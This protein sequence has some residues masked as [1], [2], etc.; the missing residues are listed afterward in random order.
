MKLHLAKQAGQRAAS[1]QVS[2]LDVSELPADLASFP[3]HRVSKATCP[4]CPGM[5]NS[6]HHPLKNNPAADSLLNYWRLSP[7]VEASLWRAHGL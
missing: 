7:Q 1:A 6:R 5:H 4:V 3:L 2:A